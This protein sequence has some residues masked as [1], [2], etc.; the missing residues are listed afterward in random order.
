MPN[1]LIN[2]YIR[3]IFFTIL[4][5]VGIGISNRSL[6]FCTPI[7]GVK[8]YDISYIT[9]LLNPDDNKAGSVHPR[10]F[11]WYVPNTTIEAICYPIDSRGS[12]YFKATI[13]NLT[14]GVTID[15][16]NY[17]VL[18]KY[19]QVASEVMIVNNGYVPT[20]FV[21]ISNRQT[22]SGGSTDFSSGSDGYI[23]L[24]IDRPFV[25][26]Q[27]IPRT[28]ILEISNSFAR[29][30][31]YNLPLSRVYLSGKVTVPQSCSI[32]SGQTINIPLGKINSRDIDTKGK[33]AENYTPKNVDIK[34]S[35]K[36]ISE[37]V[38]V[39]LSFNGQVAGGDHTALATSNEDVG[40]RIL[41]A[42]GQTVIPNQSELPVYIDFAQQAG[43]SSMTVAPINVT[44]KKPEGGPF[45][46]VA[47]MNVE[48]N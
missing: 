32:N 26:V 18:N 12:H 7:A 43:I 10:N 16:L 6:A 41:N 20:P 25:G 36:N 35:C 45:T 33:E 2:S 40:I 9:S 38:S 11:R 42:N 23:S 14:P 39:S 22:T 3:V 1:N 48:I 21:N 29:P 19:L 31:N 8:Q 15:G 17:Y 28:L 24:Y 37:G 44:G 5:L 34:I 46:A 30:D 47:T 4:L 13:P 27:I